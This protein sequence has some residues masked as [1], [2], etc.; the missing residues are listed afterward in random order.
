MRRV[1][2]AA[3]ALS[4]R[5]SPALAQALWE[6]LPPTPT[7]PRATSSGVA[8]LNGVRIWHAEF[9]QGP[10]VILLHGGLANSDYWG[11]QVRALQS[12]YRGLNLF[13]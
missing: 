2:L 10:P 3:L 13:S 7:L 5:V 8:T 12:R 6:T 1:L 11:L 4:L 9:G